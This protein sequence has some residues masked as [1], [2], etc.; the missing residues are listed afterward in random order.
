[1]E[2]TSNTGALMTNIEALTITWY[3]LWSGI[4]VKDPTVPVPE[5]ETSC[6]IE[7][8]GN[9]N[10]PYTISQI[11]IKFVPDNILLAKPN[12]LEPAL[13]CEMHQKDYPVVIDLVTR[14]VDNKKPGTTFQAQFII[15]IAQLDMYIST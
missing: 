5:Y 14:G 1:M 8:L 6:R 9:V 10:P 12:Y 4:T 2:N 11:E 7:L 13:Y 15:N 3:Q